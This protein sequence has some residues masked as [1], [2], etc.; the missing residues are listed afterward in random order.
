MEKGLGRNA[1]AVE[2]RASQITLLNDRN[3]QAFLGGEDCR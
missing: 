1:S 2:A 3:G